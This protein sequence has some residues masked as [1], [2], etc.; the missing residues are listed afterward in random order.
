[1][2]TFLIL[3]LFCSSAIAQ[4]VP[5]VSLET[6]EIN[7]AWTWSYYNKAGEFYSSE[8]YQVLEIKNG[9]VVL[10]MASRYKV[11]EP[12]RAHHRLHVNVE[13]CLKAYK[14]PGTKGAWGFQMFYWNGTYWDSAGN[15]P[16][17]AFEEKFNCNPHVTHTSNFDTLFAISIPELGAVE[18]FQQR[19][20]SHITSSW[21]FK[22]GEN[23][24]IAA[25]RVST[26][27]QDSAYGYQLIFQGSSYVLG[28]TP[29]Y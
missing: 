20:N 29:K 16:T 25:Q 22:N 8:R 26:Q 10:E 9:T 6:F 12:L 5:V 17:A 11:G 21:Y 27:E 23:A 18:I 15:V 28:P 13:N 2:K 7:K 1:M 14:N 3:F 4:T 19:Q 24:A